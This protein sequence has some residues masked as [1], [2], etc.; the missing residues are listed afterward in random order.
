MKIKKIVLLLSIL[1]LALSMTACSNGQEKVDFDYTDTSILFNSMY[2]TYQLNQIDEATKLIINNTEGQEVLQ[3]AIS[4]F[5]TANEECGDLL[6]FLAKDGSVISL[7]QISAASSES[8]EAYQQCLLEIDTEIVEDGANVKATITAVYENRN[9]E[10]SFVYEAAPA[11]ASVDETTKE[12]VVPYQ[13]AEL[14][15]SPVYTFSEQMGKAGANTLMGMGTVFIVLIFISLIIGQFEKVNKVS[16]AVGTWWSNR[17]RKVAETTEISNG[18]PS[19][20][21]SPAATPNPM[22]DTQLIAVITAA[23][24]AANVASGGSDKLVVR[25]IRKAKR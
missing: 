20:V 4:N 17:K 11:Q 5:E 16:T 19:A 1:V 10:M 24:T 18:V 8:E 9:A 22:D 21:V 13:I 25:S 2:L 15:V 3:T 7:E 23:I 6:G 14:T 12:V